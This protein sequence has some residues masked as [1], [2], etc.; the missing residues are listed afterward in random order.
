MV[1][2]RGKRIKQYLKIC[3]RGCVCHIV[4]YKEKYYKWKDKLIEYI[5]DYIEQI[6]K[7][8]LRIDSIIYKQ[9]LKI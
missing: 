7:R 1:R 9:C 4:T 8:P 3:Q 5:L 2:Y 6:T